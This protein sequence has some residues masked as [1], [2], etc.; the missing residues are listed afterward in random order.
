MVSRNIS[1]QQRVF[2][3]WKRDTQTTGDD[4]I[5]FQLFSLED[6]EAVSD[7]SIYSNFTEIIRTADEV[8]VYSTGSSK[9]AISPDE[10]KSRFHLITEQQ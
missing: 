3:E 1:A 9:L 5:T 7:T 2:S 4:I 8:Y 6:W 10:V